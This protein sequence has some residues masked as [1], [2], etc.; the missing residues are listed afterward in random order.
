MLSDSVALPAAQQSRMTA[1]EPLSAWDSLSLGLVHGT[2]IV[3]LKLI[4]LRG[5]YVLGR[6]FGTL[7]WLVNYKRRRRFAAALEDLLARPPGRR[8][9]IHWT[10]EHFRTSRCDRLFYLILDCIPAD[11]AASL[12]CLSH[13][14]LL[15]QA[16]ARGHGVYVAL[17]HHGAQH[18]IGLLLAMNGYRIA[19]VRDRREGALRRYAQSRIQ[20]KLPAGAD[21]RMLFADDY[22]RE[23]YRCFQDGYVLGSAIDVSRPRDPKQKVHELT[24]LGRTRYFLTGPLRAAL[25]CRAPVLQ[26]FIVPERGFRYRFELTE[27]LIDPE[28]VADEATAIQRAVER[29]AGHLEERTRT[30][31][32]LITRL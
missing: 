22:P 14:E 5:L 13:P 17:A 19:G 1:A 23:I 4:G 24:V 7:E 30:A 26:A 20:R 3:L 11:R 9:R 8:Q 15:D 31:P 18:V 6:A 16:V 10:L 12:L 28:N 2:L 25:R 27:M 32:H 21:F 29:Y